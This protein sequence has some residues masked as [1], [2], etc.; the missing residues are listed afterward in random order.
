MDVQSLNTL[1]AGEKGVIVALGNDT[2]LR[3]RLISR[4]VMI[5]S[6]IEIICNIDLRSPVML[7]IEDTRLAV[8]Q[9]IAR[10]ILV[11]PLNQEKGGRR[12]V[13][14][15]LKSFCPGRCSRKKKLQRHRHRYGWRR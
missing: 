6:Q 12:R 4:G 15:W 13:S 7:A 14:K 5:G 2:L 9:E 11:S 1:K 8:E 3:N 10:H